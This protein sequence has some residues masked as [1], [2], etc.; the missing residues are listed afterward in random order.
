MQPHL[1]NMVNFKVIPLFLWL[2]WLKT[3]QTSDNTGCSVP[4]AIDF[5]ILASNEH[6]CALNCRQHDCSTYF[7]KD[8][9]AFEKESNEFSK[10]CVMQMSYNQNPGA[11]VHTYHGKPLKSYKSKTCVQFTRRENKT[12]GLLGHAHQKLGG[13]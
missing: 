5:G 8:L 13:K 10:N 1:K 9:K 6:E 11:E 12:T 4:P 3:V 7:Y 2:L